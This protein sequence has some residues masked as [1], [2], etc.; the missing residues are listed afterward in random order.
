MLNK[1]ESFQPKTFLNVLMALV[2]LVTPL[3]SGF[4]T[5]ISH[6]WPLLAVF[7][8]VFLIVLIEPM[9]RLAIIPT[10]FG[11]LVINLNT[12]AQKLGEKSWLTIATSNS[13]ELW[14]S[15]IGGHATI[16]QL[17]RWPEAIQVT[18]PL[19]GVLTA[20]ILMIFAFND[21]KDVYL[22]KWLIA[23]A[24]V[25]GCLP[26]FSRGFIEVTP[27]GFPIAVSAL[28]TAGAFS[29][30]VVRK[31]RIFLGGFLA[32]CAAYFHGVYLLVPIVLLIAAFSYPKA[33]RRTQVLR[34]SLAMATG[35]IFL[36]SVNLIMGTRIITGDANGG[37]D[38]KIFPGD[39]W[40]SSHLSQTLILMTSG[41]VF[42]F[43][44]TRPGYFLRIHPKFLVAPTVF[45]VFLFFWNFDLGWRRDLDLIISS[46]VVLLWSTNS[47]TELEIQ[48]SQKINKL[49]IAVLVL[50][51]WLV[52]GQVEWI[53]V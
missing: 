4:I 12:Y 26:I 25:V 10:A 30:R 47:G 48:K 27:Y 31:E 24:V 17:A 15:S 51:I 43:Y 3:A 22:R 50:N 53:F 49:V 9:G 44:Q 36:V 5:E 19:L 38:G 42:V 29:N 40:S 13:N 11:V 1:I 16:R 37:G 45:G 41:S 52:L 21:E 23:I 7:P 6:P 34:T 2:L 14:A 18:P 20:I 32:T 46:S 8:L 28:C 35:L 39:M 33:I